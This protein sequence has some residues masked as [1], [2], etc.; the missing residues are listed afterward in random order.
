MNIPIYE[1]REVRFYLN[2]KHETDVWIG[3]Y[4]DADNY[5]IVHRRSGD[6][7]V[8]TMLVLG[9]YEEHNLFDTMRLIEELKRAGY[10]QVCPD[11]PVIT[12]SMSCSGTI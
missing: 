5:C 4:D 7:D 9:Y 8:A 3:M 10:T 2:D 12:L 1:V 11:K 6:P